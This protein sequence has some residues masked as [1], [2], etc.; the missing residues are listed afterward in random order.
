MASTNDKVTAW[1]LQ[2]LNLANTAKERGNIPVGSIVTKMNA[3]DQ[4]DVEIVSEAMEILPQQRCVTGHA[5]ILAIQ[6]ACDKL[7]TMDLSQC[8]LVTTAEPC[9]MCAYAI[10]ETKIAKV[11][12]GS[13]TAHVG[14]VTSDFNILCTETVPSWGPPPVIVTDVLRQDCD[15]LRKD[16]SVGTASAT[17]VNTY[18]NEG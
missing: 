2:C 7:Q 1:M 13:P 12:I 9:W 3:D 11:V 10:R 17:R 14:S 8:T 5:E 4:N 16:N 18:P 15:N 6:Q